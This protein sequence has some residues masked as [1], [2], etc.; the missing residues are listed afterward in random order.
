MLRITPCWPLVDEDGDIRGE[1]RSCRRS[2]AAA[3][4]LGFCLS[5]TFVMIAAAADVIFWWLCFL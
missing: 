4:N 3:P 2:A 5:P 1:D